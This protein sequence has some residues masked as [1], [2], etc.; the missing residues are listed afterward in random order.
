MTTWMDGRQDLWLQS[1]AIANTSGHH[2]SGFLLENS[3]TLTIGRDEPTQ[4]H[5]YK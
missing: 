3:L 1:H 4:Q 5:P 2:P